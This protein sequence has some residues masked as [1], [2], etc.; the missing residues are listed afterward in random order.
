MNLEKKA[1]ELKLGDIHVATEA[2][3]FHRSV[4][5]K[6]LLNTDSR[7]LAEYKAQRKV[8]KEQQK[9]LDKYEQDV[10]EIRDDVTEIKDALR[11]ILNKMSNEN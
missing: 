1:K 2:P 11:A 4:K 7:G 8:R 3:G 9:R 10:E 5:N 6:A